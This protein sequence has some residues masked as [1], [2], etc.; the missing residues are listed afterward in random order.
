MK[1]I[2]HLLLALSSIV[3]LFACDSEE[4]LPGP[5]ANPNCK[6]V[7]F[8]SSNSGRF[9]LNLGEQ[10][11][12]MLSMKRDDA[13]SA[14]S[15]P[16]KTLEKNAI[17]TIPS[18]VEFAAGSTTAQLKIGISTAAE[19]GVKYR[20]RIE[21]DGDEYVNPYIQSDGS[22]KFDGTVAF[23]KWDKYCTANFSW[24]TGT[25]Y[26][27]FTADIYKMEGEE[28]Y[29]ISDYLNSGYDLEFNVNASTHILPIGG[30]ST[31]SAWYGEYEDGT[32][33]ICYPPTTGAN[34]HITSFYYYLSTSSSLYTYM[35]ATTKVGRLY[36]YNYNSDGSGGY[37]YLN[38]TW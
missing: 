31:T 19:S 5:Q 9:N 1:K 6:P 10:D 37:N 2:K 16:I 35:N 33:V 32:S 18:S 26:K 29:R 20:F 24:Q 34:V 7:Y 14:L 25:I 12:I 4:Y 13:S 23:V 21:I 17:F 15:V 28:R 30:R 36:H 22:Y 11:H 8:A 27:P 38:F 3:L